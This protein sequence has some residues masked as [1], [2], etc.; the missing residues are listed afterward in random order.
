MRCSQCKEQCNVTLI[1]LG[2]G[3]YEFWGQ[4]GVHEDMCVVSTCCEADVY[5]DEIPSVEELLEL[6]STDWG[7]DR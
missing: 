6:E 2:I 3:P 4:P 1:D 5:G 7:W